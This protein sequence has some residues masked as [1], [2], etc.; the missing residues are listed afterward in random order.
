MG[1][2]NTIEYLEHN[3][4]MLIAPG[5]NYAT[6]TESSEIATMRSQCKSIIVEY[7]WKMIFAADEEEFN[8][9]YKMMVTKL[10]SL[11]YEQV[12]AVDMQNAHDQSEARQKA[13]EKYGSQ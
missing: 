10:S 5:C 9:L 3:D 12:L 13:V 11:G 1:A 7:S 6:P 2:E 4:M 8:S